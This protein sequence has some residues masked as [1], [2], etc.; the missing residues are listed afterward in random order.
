MWRP[1]GSALPF[2]LVTAL[3]LVSCS[4]ANEPN[5]LAP[6]SLSSMHRGAPPA[7]NRNFV[8][9]LSGAEEVPSV[10]TRARGQ[11]V[12]QLSKDGTELSYRL[13]VANL[14]NV[15]MAHIHLAPRGDNGDVVVWLYPSAPP[16][17]L[18]EGRSSGILATGVITSENLVGPLAGATLSDLFEQMSR[19][20]VYV[21]VHTV[22]NMPGEIRGQI[23]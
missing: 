8:A 19:G 13:S 10:D 18:I 23:R 1:R 11:A 2:L 12:F 14:M 20:N 7:A 15:L 5:P 16:P 21:N 6:E 9:P 4:E 22:A 3:M 17:Q